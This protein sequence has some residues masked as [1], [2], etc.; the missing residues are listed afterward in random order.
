V[1]H[2][3][4]LVNHQKLAEFFFANNFDLK[5][6]RLVFFSSFSNKKNNRESCEQYNNYIG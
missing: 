4:F 2:L 6:R 5:L 3:T 1:L